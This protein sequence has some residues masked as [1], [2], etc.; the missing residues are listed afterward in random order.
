MKVFLS[1]FCSPMHKIFGLVRLRPALSVAIDVGEQ[2]ASRAVA[3]VRQAFAKRLQL[4]VSKP[5]GEFFAA[6]FN[7]GLPD[8]FAEF[9]G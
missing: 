2:R 3:Y 8:T 6:D 7:L 5:F 4:V 9:F 1:G